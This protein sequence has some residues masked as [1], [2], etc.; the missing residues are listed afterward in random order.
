MKLSQIVYKINKSMLMSGVA[1]ASS[2]RIEARQSGEGLA[3]C[4]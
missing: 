1:V 4:L 3:G 2:V